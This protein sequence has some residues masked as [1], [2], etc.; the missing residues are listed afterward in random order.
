MSD[1]HRVH[2]S[3]V[4]RETNNNYGFFLSIWGRLFDTCV[5]Q[6]N[7]GHD[8]V[9]IGRSEYQI[10]QPSNPIWMLLTP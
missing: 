4:I 7:A 10:K 6:P 2:H 8:Q 1:M 5:A 9:T 3:I